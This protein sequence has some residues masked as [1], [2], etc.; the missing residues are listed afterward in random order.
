VLEQGLVIARLENISFL[1][2]FLTGPLGAAYSLAGQPDRGVSLLEQT[3]EQAEAI[4]LLAGHALRLVW[5]GDANLRAGRPEVARGL[6]WRALQLAEE[7]KERGHAAHAL[8]L[9]GDAAAAGETPDLAGAV[10]A[11]RQG[12]A[13]AEALGMSPLVARCRLAL[14][15]VDLRVGEVARAREHLAAAA[16]GFEAMAMTDWLARA[17]A[18]CARAGAFTRRGDVSGSR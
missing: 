9:V 4:R 13:L 1:V 2:P 12:L 5:L 15:E 17:R 18:G 14:G 7:R 8:C 16:A 10:T 11:Y 6:A 3:V